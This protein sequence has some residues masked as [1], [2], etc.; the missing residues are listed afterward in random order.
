[1]SSSTLDDR[2][3][4]R[5]A[6]LVTKVIEDIRVRGLSPGDRYLTSEEA[7]RVF[8]VQKSVLNEA[9][10]HLADRQV[11]SRQRRSG[12]FIGPAF[13]ADYLPSATGLQAVH[14]LTTLEWH[15]TRTIR[16]EQFV[17]TLNSIL[18]DVA[19]HVRYMPAHNAATVTRQV[20]DQIRS[21][22]QREGLVLIFSSHETQQLVADS[23]LPAVNFG[24]VYPG[25]EGLPSVEGDQAGIGRMMAR[26]LVDRQHDR[27]VYLTRNEWRRGD[28]IVLEAISQELHRANVSLDGLTIRSVAPVTEQVV[29]EIR[30][31]LA[32]PNPPTAF[33]C[34]TDFYADLVIRETEE[35]GVKVDVV[36]GGRDEP[37]PYPAVRPIMCPEEQIKQLAHMLA[38]RA[39]G[40]MP[41]PP[42]V[43][44]PVELTM[45]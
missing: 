17:E 22:R 16:A 41:D 34:R 6:D 25:I 12:T 29:S 4:P 33:M 21:S 39:A 13:Q 45:S 14:V 43:I 2:L 18:P 26:Y 15:R 30:D 44:I 5:V 40:R 24:S 7:Q 19:V 1:M 31:I 3:H 27:F 35:L 8:R 36:S 11:L 9:M 23:G 10:R 20:I 32:Q 38:A 37:R 42:H 28:N